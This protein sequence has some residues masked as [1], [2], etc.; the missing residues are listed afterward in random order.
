MRLLHFS[1]VH[2]SAEFRDVPIH[3]WVGKRGLAGLNLLLGRGKRF[4]EAP[5]KLRALAR[6]A[7]EQKFDAVLFTGDYTALGLEREFRAAREAVEPLMHAPAGYVNVP[8]NHDLYLPEVLR[9]ERFE[10]FFG[11]TLKSDLPDYQ[12]GGPWPLVRWVGEQIAVVAVNSARPNPQPWRS[13]GVI[14]EE[15]LAALADLLA[16][17]AV[18]SR[19]VF[20]LTHDAPRLGDGSRDTKLH[21]MTNADD[22]LCVCADLPRGAILCG[23]S[24]HGFHLKVPGVGPPILCS[25]STTMSGRETL[26]VYE[27]DQSAASATRGKWDGE[28]YC[29][30]PSSVVEL[31]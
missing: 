22:F 15:Q 7:Q 4:A 12:T 20:V 9:A 3:R 14:P 21:G 18:R 31:P 10:R 23:H 27:V 25:G 17:E 24:H 16:D 6:F 13:S 29:L 19:V 11:D 28:G 26:W 30:D 1:D 5:E 8:G 2:V